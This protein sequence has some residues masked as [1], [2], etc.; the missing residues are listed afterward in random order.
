MAKCDFYKYENGYDC[1]ILK[2]KIRGQ[3]TERVN[4]DI[5]RD[6]C[7]YDDGYKKCPFY[8]EYKKNQ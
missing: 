7:R 5:F 4:S 1:C 3:D 8:D 6:Y 2:G